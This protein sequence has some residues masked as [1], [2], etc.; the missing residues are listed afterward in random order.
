M[1]NTEVSST[2]SSKPN[3]KVLPIARKELVAVARAEPKVLKSVSEVKEPKE[4]P[5]VYFRCYKQYA[6]WKTKHN[7]KNDSVDTIKSFIV[8]CRNGYPTGRTKT[9]E[10]LRLKYRG[11]VHTLKAKDATLS[12]PPSSEILGS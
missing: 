6:V 5:T 4:V 8:D 12:F 3:L 2:V 7:V 11:I 9:V 10:S 1:G